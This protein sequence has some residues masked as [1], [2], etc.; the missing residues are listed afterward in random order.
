MGVP[1]EPEQQAGGPQRWVQQVAQAASRTCTDCVV[2]NQSPQQHRPSVVLRDLSVR[3]HMTL[4]LRTLIERKNLRIINKY[5]SSKS[6]DGQL[7]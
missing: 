2:T 1:Y 3:N 5:G 4:V 7:A 6:F